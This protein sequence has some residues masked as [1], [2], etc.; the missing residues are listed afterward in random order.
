MRVELR[1]ELARG[2]VDKAGDGEPR[3]D[4]PVAALEPA[5]CPPTFVLEE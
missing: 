1:V 4:V 3:K 2:G 5:P